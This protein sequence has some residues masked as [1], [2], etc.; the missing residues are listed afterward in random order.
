MGPLDL[1]AKE[2]RD[3]ETQE[4]LFLHDRSLNFTFRGD[5]DPFRHN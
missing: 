5:T 2:E 4:V 3:K 1:N